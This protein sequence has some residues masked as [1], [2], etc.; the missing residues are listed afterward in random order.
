MIVLVQTLVSHQLHFL[1]LPPNIAGC[2][3]VLM[4]ATVATGAAA[5][6][7]IR[8]LLVSH[9]TVWGS[10]EMCPH[11]ALN[12]CMS[13][14]HAHTHTHTHSHSLLGPRCPRRKYSLCVHPSCPAWGALCSIRISPCQDCDFCDRCTRGQA[15]PHSAW[16]GK[17]R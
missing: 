3:V 8:V 7:A 17:L 9:D 13:S 15:L 5:I 14:V 10:I 2:H 12:T 6:M 16:R 1:R 4:D 11:G